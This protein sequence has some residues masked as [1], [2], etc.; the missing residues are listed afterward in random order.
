MLGVEGEIECA[1]RKKQCAAREGDG[2][3]TDRVIDRVEGMEVG[4][5]WGALYSDTLP[6]PER[7]TQET[8]PDVGARLPRSAAWTHAATSASKSHMCHG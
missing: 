8:S 5:G 3:A 7:Y 2:V 1:G 6:E 4:R